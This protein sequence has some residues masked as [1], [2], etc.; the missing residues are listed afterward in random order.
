M[1]YV[2]THPNYPKFRVKKGVMPDFSGANIADGEIPSGVMDGVNREFKVANRPLKGSEKIFKDGL[3][4][5]RATSV[6][7]T[8]GDYFIDYETKTITFSK[9][10][11]PQE[12]SIIRVDYK[13]MKIG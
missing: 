4:M 2:R 7:M 10:Q 5:G 6:A 11:I 1:A 13:Y 12:N 8:D 3:K 9:T